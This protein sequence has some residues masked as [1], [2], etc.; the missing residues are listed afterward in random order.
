MRRTPTAA[1]FSV[2]FVTLL[3]GSRLLS[4]ARPCGG[5]LDNRQ[6]KLKHPGKSKVHR[7][8]AERV[9]ESDLADTA[10]SANA[11]RGTRDGIYFSFAEKT[12]VRGNK[13]TRV[14]YGLHYMYSDDNLFE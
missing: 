5:R 4:C 3:T 2:C 12:T 7:D 6:R 9:C 8:R 11:I 13:I 14:R 10:S 1:V